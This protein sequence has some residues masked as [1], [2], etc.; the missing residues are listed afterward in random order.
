MKRGTAL[1]LFL[2]MFFLLPELSYSAD[3][4]DVLEIFSMSS[5]PV[6]YDNGQVEWSIRQIEGNI[7]IDDRIRGVGY[8]R[9]SSED[10]TRLEGNWYDK[11]YNIVKYSYDGEETRFVSEEYSFVYPG[12]YTITLS[13]RPIEVT[14]FYP[15]M[16]TIKFEVECPGYLH[17]CEF[18]E[19]SIDECYRKG[20]ELHILL[21][22]IGEKNYS[23]LNITRD[24]EFYLNYK[25]VGGYTEAQ[26]ILKA[27]KYQRKAS[28]HYEIVIPLENMT[29]NIL[30]AAIKV[31][32]CNEKLYDVFSY[33]SCG[34]A[35]E[36]KEY[37]NNSHK[38]NIT[39]ETKDLDTDNTT[40]I[41]MTVET[42]ATPIVNR[43]TQKLLVVE[44]FRFIYDMVPI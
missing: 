15:S 16:K 7:R 31:G 25:R 28:D 42:G 39:T 22:G 24:I 23:K 19:V 5:K 35:L 1:V 2:A 38:G 10:Y 41:N 34:V 44:L 21:S 36:K 13:P 12:N 26:Y 17:S 4:D 6:C 40:A 9:L 37:T 29:E 8:R 14:D 30:S 20:K 33:S 43:T 32:G 11:D 18:L 27:E 3:R